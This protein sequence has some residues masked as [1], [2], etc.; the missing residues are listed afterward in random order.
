[1]TGV[2]TCA[3]PIS[4]VNDLPPGSLGHRVTAD[5]Q[6]GPQPQ[7]FVAQRELD[8]AVGSWV[9]TPLRVGDS[10]VAVLRGWLPS[11]TAAAAAVTQGPVR[12]DG[13]LQPF[14]DFYAA[15]PRRSDGQ[16]VAISRPEIERA[17]GTQVLAGVVVLT[18][19]V[20][21]SSPAPLPVPA[22]I[23]DV[24]VPLP[25]QNAAYTVQWFIFA[26]FV[27]VMWWVWIRRPPDSLG[28]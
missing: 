24:S 6:Y 25:W 10:T 11:T 20:P 18:G 12:V 27:W 5:G 3:L 22:T 13:V 21:M 23:S 15:Q 16:L 19:Q 17:W 7:Q 9:V 28:E 14:E 1:M 8:G 2:Q 26:I 4:T